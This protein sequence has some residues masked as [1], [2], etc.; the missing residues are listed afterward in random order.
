MNED[1]ESQLFNLDELKSQ[2]LMQSSQIELNYCENFPI[3]SAT[4]K[5]V[6][7]SQKA[8]IKLSSFK[9]VREVAIRDQVGLVSHVID[10]TCAQN[11]RINMNIESWKSL[12]HFSMIL[13]EL[14]LGSTELNV[15]SRNE[16][17]MRSIFEGVK[18]RKAEALIEIEILRVQLPFFECD[19]IEISIVAN[20]NIVKSIIN[21]TNNSI[22]HIERFLWYLKL[23]EFPHQYDL[24]DFVI[25][26]YLNEL[27][28]NL[29]NT[30]ISAGWISAKLNNQSIDR[31]KLGLV[32]VEQI[33]LSDQIKSVEVSSERVIG[34]MKETAV[35]AKFQLISAPIRIG[36][37][38][39]QRRILKH[40]SRSTL[41][42]YDSYLYTYVVD[43]D[44][45]EEES[46]DFGDTSSELENSGE[47][48][49]RIIKLFKS[50]SY[51]C[52][53]LKAQSCILI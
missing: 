40:Q 33:K 5:T 42:S 45:E 34:E 32:V 26:I 31:I 16:I 18:V 24:I 22:I 43:E 21:L 47:F 36:R 17:M 6:F 49:H 20:S 3:D 25:L 9:C 1:A 37:Y 12:P 10:V 29:S 30:L 39:E 27:N 50:L 52:P 48:F 46:E 8:S 2:L 11:A 4:L 53:V 44:D 41:S 15:T 28:I 14:S 7:Y 51:K 13:F 23:F 19:R 35:D 38:R